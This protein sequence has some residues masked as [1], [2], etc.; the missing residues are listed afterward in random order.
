M[1]PALK[2]A[3]IKAATFHA[4][5]HSYAAWM[6]SEG[7]S[8]KFVQLQLGHTDPAF[9]LRST[10]IS[11]R[12]RT[13]NWQRGCKRGSWAGWSHQNCIISGASKKLI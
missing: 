1:A 8:P 7:E 12:M 2:K 6:L 4:L 9:T 3:K 13:G 5:R 11:C 10:D